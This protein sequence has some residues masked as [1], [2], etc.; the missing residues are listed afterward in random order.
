M[1]LKNRRRP[2]VKSR[3]SN[4]SLQ[5]TSG[6]FD[7]VI[8]Q[9]VNLSLYLKLQNLFDFFID[10]L[11]DLTIVPHYHP[12]S[13]EYISQCID[14]IEEVYTE[15]STVINIE[16]QNLLVEFLEDAHDF[17]DLIKTISNSSTENVDLQAHLVQFAAKASHIKWLSV[18]IV[19]EMKMSY[20]HA[21][22]KK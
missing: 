9:Q 14:H 19:Q 22:L 20:V 15:N 5:K 16:L 1:P 11:N 17:N 7:A 8:F 13:A 18:C 3:R 4:S 12:G 2:N 21:Y 6:V 10:C